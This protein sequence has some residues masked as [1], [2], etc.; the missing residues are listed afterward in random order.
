MT[1]VPSVVLMGP[2][3][4]TPGCTPMQTTLQ[5]LSIATSGAIA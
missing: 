2:L 1:H 4:P 3:E 5:D